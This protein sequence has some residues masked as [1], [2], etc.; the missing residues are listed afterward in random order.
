[1]T[2]AALTWDEVFEDFEA[3]QAEVAANARW[4]NLYRAQLV[5]D[6]IARLRPVLSLMLF[7]AVG[8]C[9]MRP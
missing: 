9:V 7:V 2:A 4:Y 1:M 5:F 3:V 8:V 6:E